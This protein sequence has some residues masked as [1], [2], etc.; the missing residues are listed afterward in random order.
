MH[1]Y[2]VSSSLLYGFR[3]TQFRDFF[4]K[5][6]LY[7]FRK[8][9]KTLAEALYIYSDF[10]KSSIIFKRELLYDNDRPHVVTFVQ[11]YF[12]KCNIYI[13]SNPP[14]C[15]DFVPR[16]FWMFPISNKK[17]R[18]RLNARSGVFSAVQESLTQFK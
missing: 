4:E 3:T 11:K 12:S 18:S 6:H 13:M 10:N 17:L 14:Y 15:R 9:D 16:N 8:V 1:L 7:L 5:K 2:R